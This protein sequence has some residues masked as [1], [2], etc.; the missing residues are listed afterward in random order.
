MQGEF[1]I[2]SKSKKLLKMLNSWSSDSASEQINCL[3]MHTGGEALRIV[4]SGY[5]DLEGSSML[6]KRRFAKENFDQLRTTLMY[7]PRG[8]TDMYGCLITDPV[9]KDADFGALFMHNEGYSTM[10]G[11]AIIAITTALIESNAIQKNTIQIDTPAGLIK[12]TARIENG[13]V[14]SAYF[15]NVPSF[16]DELD[17]EIEV[18]NIGTIKYDLAFGGAY[19]AF[20]NADDLGIKMSPENNRELIDL[21]MR[22]KNQIINSRQIKHPSETD[23]SFLYGTIFIGAAYSSDNDSRNVCIFADGEVDRSPTGTGV[24]A[25]MAIHYARNELK[26][27]QSMRIESIIGSVFTASIL[28][29]TDFYGKKAVIAQVEGSAYISGHSSFIIDPND[30]LKNGF[31]IR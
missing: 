19:Y 2:E 11:H 10:C 31:L 27:G 4:L 29:E 15:E 22:I 6:E 5:P 21:G 3:D 7:E 16:V 24:S 13:K 25:R 23:L 9:S 28:S 14:K 17:A 1:L 26:V 18:K 12:S 8:H 20:V 30:P